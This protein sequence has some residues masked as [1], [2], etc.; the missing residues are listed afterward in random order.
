MR[1]SE[2]ILNKQNVDNINYKEKS[3]PKLT[4][5]LVLLLIMAV[6][7][8]IGFAQAIKNQTYMVFGLPVQEMKRQNY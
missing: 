3:M 7:I 4:R 1:R 5:Q 6:F 8:N 2:N